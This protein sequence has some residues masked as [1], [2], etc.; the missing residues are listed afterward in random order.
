VP[1]ARK[2][3]SARKQFS[4]GGVV[5]R[6]TSEGPEFVL[7][8]ADGRWSLPKGNIE[9][10]EKPE[11]TALREISEET[12]LPLRQLRIVRPLPEVTYAFQWNGALVFKVVYNFLVELIGDAPLEPQL[13][14][15]QDVR[16]FGPAVA[17]RTISFKN[18]QATLDAAIT[19][20]EELKRAS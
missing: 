19:G 10:G 14:E 11:A 8:E 6:H 18:S 4:A 20:L 1:A 7:I 16:W 3:G 9:K 12:G 5:F 2:S 13:S 17:R 15:I